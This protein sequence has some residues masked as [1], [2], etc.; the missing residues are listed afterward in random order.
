MQAKVLEIKSMIKVEEKRTVHVGDFFILENWQQNQM[1]Q[2]QSIEKKTGKLDK[3]I[4]TAKAHYKNILAKAL[5]S[6]DIANNNLKSR[7]LLV[8]EKEMDEL[9]AI[10]LQKKKSL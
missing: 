2:I 8:E 3:K 9:L 4:Y 10:V 5:M 7:N 6:E 1:Y